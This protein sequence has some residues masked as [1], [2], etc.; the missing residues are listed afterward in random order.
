MSRYHPVSCHLSHDQARKLMNGGT[1]ALRREMCGAGGSH[2]VHLTMHQHNRL[3]KGNGI[4]LYFSDTQRK[5]N[6]KHG[7]GFLDLVKAGAKALAPVALNAGANLL[8]DQGLASKLLT[9]IHPKL[10]A[11]LGSAADSALNY[12]VDAGNNAAKNAIAGSGVHKRGRKKGKGLYPA[13]YTGGGIKKHHAKH[14]KEHHHEH[15]EEHGHHSH[16]SHHEHHKHNHH[17]GGLFPP[18]YGGSLLPKPIRGVN[19]NAAGI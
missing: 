9:K 3:S 1:V 10:G 4:R 7:K 12:G 6:V 2:M 19:S 18:G 15:R 11:A 16:H 14:H 17:G 13:G 8:K 5:H